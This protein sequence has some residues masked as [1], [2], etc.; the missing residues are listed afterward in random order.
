MRETNREYIDSYFHNPSELEKSS[1][2]WPIRVGKN[3]AKPN[4][5]VGPRIINHF[6][7]HFILQGQLEFQEGDLKIT[8]IKND[9]FCAFPSRN[10][11][12]S[13]VPS[14]QPLRLMWVAFDGTQSMSL[15]QQIGITPEHPYQRKV[16]SISA[17]HAM[18]RITSEVRNKQKETLQTI[19]A[20]YELF[21]S[22]IEAVEPDQ[23][24]LNSIKQLI[25]KGK[26]YMDLH[27]DENLQI[28]DIAN[29]LYIHRSQFTKYFQ[30]QLGMSPKKYTQKLKMEKAKN[31]LSET[32][33]SI[34][35]IALTLG[36][37]DLYSFTRA[38]KNYHGVSP[39]TFKSSISS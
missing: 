32:T 34:T 12:Y 20:M 3:L 5:N 2:I 10:H 30:Q 36:Y 21:H 33:F 4:Y 26:Q 8:L 27:L 31:I 39:T 11:Q 35:E 14:E 28:Q 25:E 23:S 38:F 6:S 15:L 13:H 16:L 17:I 29:L 24:S 19:S 18:Q 1:A 7:L 9:A 37:P 22:M